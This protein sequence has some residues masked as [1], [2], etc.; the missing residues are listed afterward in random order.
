MYINPDKAGL[1]D[2]LINQAEKGKIK[3]YQDEL[4]FLGYTKKQIS[5]MSPKDSIICI[6]AALK[7][8]SLPKAE[9]TFDGPRG[10]ETIIIS[11]D[12]P[13]DKQAN[14]DQTYNGNYPY[15]DR[16][17]GTNYNMTYTD[18]AGINK[19]KPKSSKEITGSR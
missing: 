14:S 3:E 6:L 10:T 16:R 15:F 12:K 18:S 5:E 9:F 17:D 1:S 2:N 11:K 19:E 13:K 8:N 4:L 7:N